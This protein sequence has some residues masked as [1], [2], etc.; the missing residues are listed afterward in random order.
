MNDQD[1]QKKLRQLNGRGYPQYKSI[2]GHFD[3]GR[4]DLQIM[5]VQGDPFAMPSRIAVRITNSDL[6][7][8][9]KDLAS[10]SRRI[11]LEDAILRSFFRVVSRTGKSRGTG[12]SGQWRILT[13]GQEMLPRTA[14][15][16]DPETVT[17]RFTVGLPAAGRRILGHEATEMF[18]EELPAIVE[19][20]AYE[21]DR[22]KWVE[23]AD[24]FEDQDHLRHLLAEKKWVSFVANESLLPRAS[25]IDD[26]PFSGKAVLWDSPKELRTEV[27]LPNQGKVA[28][29]FIPEGVTLIC[30]GGYHG[31][32]TLLHALE[33]GIYNHIP[34]D[35]RE[36]CVTRNDALSVR[37]EDGRS[38]AQV[39]ISPFINDL[40]TGADTT[41]FSTENASGSTSQAANLVEN[42]EMGARVFLIDEDTSATNFMVRDRRMQELV[43]TS[44]EPITPFI[45]RVK[46]LHRE[47]GISSVLVIGG[48]GD[49]FD[50]ADNVLLMEGFRPRMATKEAKEIASKYPADRVEELRPHLTKPAH[51]APLPKSFDPS[52]GHRSEKVKTTGTRIILFGRHEIDVSLVGQLMDDGQT[53]TL[54][55]WLIRCSRG[56]ADGERSLLS[57]C[58]ELEQESIEKSLSHTT[59]SMDGDRVFARSFELAAAINRM[60]TLSVRL[61]NEKS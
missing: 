23:H 17:V 54:A 32:S 47:F 8:R 59:S 10:F 9:A 29:S 35:G 57:I 21:G 52:R 38:V 43:S 44:S 1:L 11:G 60:R 51:R 18:M 33:R 15:E 4:F 19:K 48:A 50:V 28:G 46:D 41:S 27:E 16:I 36:L 13:P 40:P 26:R 31:K 24:A 45:D 42:I 39:D 37:A 3:F 49:Y 55:D 56:L 6:K 12:K 30:G 5:H 61:K 25:G 34:G 22:T 7:L 2:K 58:K 20:A 14:V 53:R